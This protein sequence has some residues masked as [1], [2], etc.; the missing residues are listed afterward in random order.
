MRL[1]DEFSTE[2][3]LLKY[4][5]APQHLHA[6]RQF[7]VD[8]V[9][10]AATLSTLKN[11]SIDFVIACHV[12]E[13]VPSFL[14]TLQTFARVLRRGGVALVALPDRR[15]ALPDPRFAAHDMPRKTTSPATHIREWQ[16]NVSS[17]AS[18]RIAHVAEALAAARESVDVLN[19]HRGKGVRVT[20]AHVRQAS[21]LVADG[22][23]TGRHLYLFT[24]DSIVQTLALAKTFGFPMTLVALEQETNEN[25]FVLQ[26]V[27]GR[28]PLHTGFSRPTLPDDCPRRKTTSGKYASR[29]RSPSQNAEREAAQL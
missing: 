5:N 28:C 3:L 15:F 2:G 29:R 6:I 7:P 9:D 8:I 21:R 24:T 19:L 25:I 13:H 27:T 11:E 20:Q 23:S 4:K 17:L 14:G 12:L 1:L 16:M 22:T 26:K 10:D 18:A